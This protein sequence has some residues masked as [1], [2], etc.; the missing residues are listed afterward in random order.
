MEQT[1]LKKVDMSFLNEEV[2]KRLNTLLP[3]LLVIL[4]EHKQIT[5]T[6]CLN[7]I[8]DIQNDMEKMNDKYD[9]NKTNIDSILKSLYN[10]PSLQQM[11][12]KAD[13]E[14]CNNLNNE[15]RDFC[16][17]NCKKLEISMDGMNEEINKLKIISN[18]LNEKTKVALRF[19]DWY[20]SLQLE[21]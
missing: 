3:D 15:S 20:S 6:Q 19:V 7:F 4:K 14:Y 11:E 1:I 9:I 2:I 5:P 18:S 17:N 10:V 12:I 8:K 21:T 13:K 16:K